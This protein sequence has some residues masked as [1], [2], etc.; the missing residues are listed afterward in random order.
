MSDD[1]MGL[2]GAEPPPGEVE[3]R[4]SL[5]PGASPGAGR[6]P[7]GL[8]LLELD[9]VEASVEVPP[10][11]DGSDAVSTAGCDPDASSGISSPQE[12]QNLKFAGCSDP[13]YGQRI[14]S[15]LASS[16][17]SASCFD[18]GEPQPRQNL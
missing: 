7:D 15:A 2:G 16:G 11:G 6:P 10:E 1:E 5:M 17:S 14:I 4:P 8:V 18:S 9:V 13:Q 3:G 12:P